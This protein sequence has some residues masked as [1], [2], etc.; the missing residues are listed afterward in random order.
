MKSLKFIVPMVVL[1]IAFAFANGCNRTDDVVPVQ[2]NANLHGV[3]AALE[4]E[5]D[6]QPHKTGSKVKCTAP[7]RIITVGIMTTADFDA[8]TV[9]HATVVFEGATEAHAEDGEP[10]RNELD[11]DEDGDL[12][13]ILHFRIGDTDLTCESTEACLTGSTFGGLEIWGCDRIHM[14]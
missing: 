13:L 10:V 1:A 2:S 14:F 6:I 11:V 12:D 8:T 7:S 3:V 9:D 4:V 5:I